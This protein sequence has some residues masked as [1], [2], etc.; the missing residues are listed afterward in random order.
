MK[1]TVLI[2]SL[3][4]SLASA[5]KS[6]NR[7]CW[8]Y[9]TGQLLA[10]KNHTFPDE[11]PDLSSKIDPIESVYIWKKKKISDAEETIAL[12]TKVSGRIYRHNF[13]FCRQNG[14]VK[15]C[16]GECDSGHFMVDKKMRIKFGQ[17]DFD[18]EIDG[19]EPR[20]ILELRGAKE[21]QW[22]KSIKVRC[23]EYVIE[24]LHVCYDHK[25]TKESVRYYGCVRSKKSCKSIGKKH[26]GRYGDDGAAESAFYRCE[27][28][29]PNRN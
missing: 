25:K 26:F 9:D 20:T 2:L 10:L 6:S 27:Q 29:R 1:K 16:G 19:K 17:I 13:I 3:C 22:I 4:L 7:T 11:K 12:V 15:E 24:G 18:E 8:S 21:E 23:P 14:E 5:E 28:N